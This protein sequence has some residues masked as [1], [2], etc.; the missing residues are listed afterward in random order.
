MR[1]TIIL[2]NGDDDYIINNKVDADYEQASRYYV[3]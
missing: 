3:D 2:L 1:T